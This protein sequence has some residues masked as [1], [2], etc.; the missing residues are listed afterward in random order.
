MLYTM[1]DF[2]LFVNLDGSNNLELWLCPYFIL[3]SICEKVEHSERAVEKLLNDVN[4]LKG[5]IK[6]RKQAQMQATRK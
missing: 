4:R 3:Q 6:K 5:E 1:K 2:V